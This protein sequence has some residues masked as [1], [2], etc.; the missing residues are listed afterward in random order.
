MQ[1][2]NHLPCRAQQPAQDFVRD[3]FVVLEA[4]LDEDEIG[5]ARVC[6]ESL[7]LSPAPGTACRR[8]HNT[9]LPLRWNDP[10]IQL[11]LS[12]ERRLQTLSR[13]VGANDLRWISGYVSIKEA[14]SPALWW[15]QDWWCWDH[16]VSY[17]R[18]APQIAVLCYLT[19]TSTNNGALR[20]L[21]GSH[22]KSAPIH[23]V[24]PVAHGHAAENVG[25]EHAAMRDLSGQVT[26]SLRAGDAAVLDYRLLHGTHGNASNARRDSILLSFT[27][28]WKT[29]PDDVRAHLID[30]PAQPCT[31][32]MAEMTQRM[33][34]VLPAFDGKRRSLPL[35]RNA[36][37]WFEI[38]D[39]FS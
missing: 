31:N 29:L 28:S 26:L 33:W 27:P 37:S 11:A 39:S 30:H 8:P 34:Q 14:R 6:I 16:A 17:Q 23:A 5:K 20:V 10:I 21:P 19:D 2:V 22:A 38:G 13:A 24:L 3:G 32:E 18:A 25:A 36:P 9:L 12:R 15:H 7:I 35:N 1:L 4:F